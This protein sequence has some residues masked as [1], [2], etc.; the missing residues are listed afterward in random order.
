MKTVLHWFRRDLRVIDN[1]ALVE[2]SRAGETVVPV[3]VVED[4]FRTGRDV[5]GVRVSFLMRSLDSLAKNLEALGY[6]LVVRSGRSETVIPE[7]A[8]ETG[9][10]AVGGGVI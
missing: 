8:K 5:G 6:Q 3:F 2:A 10:Q 9:A 4:A 1:T 7:L